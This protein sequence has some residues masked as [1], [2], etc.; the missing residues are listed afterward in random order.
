QLLFA[1]LPHGDQDIYLYYGNPQAT[2]TA[3]QDPFSNPA[4]GVTTNTQPE[5]TSPAPVAHW[6]FDEGYGST[7]NS[8]T[9]TNYPGIINGAT[10]QQED[11]C[12]SGKCLYFDGVDDYV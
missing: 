11:M 2:N 10:W 3:V 9:P 7:T 12:P 6:K 1:S 4:T 8:S 5:Q